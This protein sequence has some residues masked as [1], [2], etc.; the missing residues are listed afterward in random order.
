MAATGSDDIRDLIPKEVLKDLDELD[1]KLKQNIKSL[2]DMLKPVQEIGKEFRNIA[3]DGK[4]VIDTINRW[5]Q[6]NR[7]VNTNLTEQQRLLRQRNQLQERLNASNSQEVRDIIRLRDEINRRNRVTRDQIRED[8][9]ASG[10]VEQLTAR[11]RR[12]RSELNS[13]SREDRNGSIGDSIRSQIDEINSELGRNQGKGGLF[14]TIF[15]GNFWANMATQA[16][17][18]IGDLIGKAKEFVSEGIE[19]A[20]KA[21]GI[22]T[23]FE[24]LDK[25]EL[26]NNL[27]AETKGLVTDLDLMQSAVRA[28]N[29][30]IPLNNLGTLL[31]F[32]Q[33]R[34]QETGESVDYLV[35]SIING[36]GRKSPLILDNLGISASRL[37]AQVKK[38]GDFAG[39]VIQIVNEELEKQGDL[40]L[41][42]ADKQAQASVKVQN[43]QLKIGEKLL[44]VQ[45]VV[46]D[47][48]SRFADW[49]TSVAYEYLPKILSGIEN[50]LNKLID[51]YNGNE[52]VRIGVQGIIAAFKILLNTV[53]FVIKTQMK[54]IEG[55]VDGL[56]AAT[57][58]D[59]DGVKNA[60]SRTKNE[61]SK[62]SKDLWESIKK[63]F[64]NA[65]VEVDVKLN[66]VDITSPR[67][68]DPVTPTNGGGGG[69]GGSEDKKAAKER[70]RLA[71]AELKA[72]QDHAEYLIKTYSDA[73]KRIVADTKA[74]YIDRL[75]ALNVYVGQQK[76]LLGQQAKDEIALLQSKSGIK[77]YVEFQEKYA[78]QIAFINEKA[79]TEITKIDEE[80]YKLR[81]DLSTFHAEK[82]LEKISYYAEQETRAINVA[83]SDALSHLAKTYGEKGLTR[84]QYEAEQ[85]KIVRQAAID[86]F[87]AEISTLEESL[88]I[89]ELN[90][91]QRRNLEK[92]LADARVNYIKYANSQIISDEEK[93]ASKLEE[94]RKN[95]AERSKELLEES[96]NLFS[97]LQNAS[98]D[99]ELKRLEN[100]RES[101]DEY[102]DERTDRVERLEESGA[103]SKEQAD[104]RKALIDQQ[105]KARN[106]ELDRQQ[107]EIE[108]RR[109]QFQQNMA[110]L[111]IIRE[112]ASAIFRIRAQAAI[113]AANPLTAALAPIALAQI[114][115]VVATSAA[116][117]GAIMAAEIPEYAKGTAD[118]KGGFAVV[119]D[120][121]RH[122][123]AVL[124]DGRIWKTPDKDTLVN[125][126]AHTQVMPDFDKAIDKMAFV[127]LNGKPENNTVVI[128]EN[129]EQ[130]DLLRSNNTLMNKLI[131]GQNR[132]RA[133]T[134]HNNFTMSRKNKI[135]Q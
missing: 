29:F 133:T 108:K 117:I 23:A 96:L 122:E 102:Y 43:A 1:A 90:A 77:N 120:G 69:G 93:T 38:T 13:L 5:S 55:L 51:I 85:T 54:L 16:V 22:T 94:I 88:S 81:N 67:K 39:G 84:E 82:Q 97:E 103:I 4:S 24:K 65:V 119:G 107:A 26:L 10:S 116:Q 114:P 115:I 101:E 37:Q 126:P 83:E 17:S 129:K 19:M 80:A 47:L 132:L 72:E 125:L 111:D 68:R 95:L 41:T 30:G 100:Q 48:K 11:L 75:N 57:N 89:L 99:R 127:P 66:R 45:D 106:E 9:A 32:A 14:G 20:A 28:Q 35:E 18:A 124:P 131:S 15:S 134:M 7:G 61:I 36:I 92:Q 12:L 135:K 118:H 58:L 74:S 104:A 78:K 60:F 34:A 112:M 2:G 27:R 87:E 64:N 113:L 49:L 73:Q 71:Q 46:S 8:N 109:A 52:K 79:Q 63:D 31:K 21:E 123:L 128:Q 70:E 44:F 130:I 40:S 110:K 33:Q 98:Y 76:E 3:R 56:S 105:Q 121:G 25:P 50:Y 86:R 91:D 6:I 62:D 53:V 59:F 42:S